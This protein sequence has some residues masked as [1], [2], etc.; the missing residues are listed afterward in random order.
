MQQGTSINPTIVQDLFDSAANAAAKGQAQFLTPIEF[1]QALA[2]GL[3]EHRPVI[4]DLNCGPGQLLQAVRNGSTQHL[5]G[6][7]IE[8]CRNLP[9]VAVERITADLTR[10]YPLLVETDWKA[11]LFALN[12]PWD[13][14]WYRDRLSLLAESEAEAVREAFAQR[15][16]RLGPDTIDSTVATLMIALDRC[17][18]RGEGFLIANESTLQRLI[19]GEGAPYGGLA[20]HIWWHAVYDGNTVTGEERIGFDH[21]QS[22]FK[23]GV[24]YFSRSHQTG[25]GPSDQSISRAWHRGSEVRQGYHCQTDTLEL[26]RGVREEWRRQEGQRVPQPYNIWLQGDVIRTGLSVFQEHSSKV[27]KTEARE[28]YQ[29]NQKRPMDLVLQRHT[30]DL[31]FRLVGETK[32]EGRRQK[33]EDPAPNT[34]PSSFHWRV[35]PALVAEVQRCWLAYQACR[36]PLYPLPKIQRLGYLEE[37]DSIQ[38]IEDFCIDEVP[39]FRRGHSYPLRTKTIAVKRKGTK[40]NLVGEPESLEYTGQELATW[41][42][43]DP[44]EDHCFLDARA[45]ANGVE[46]PPL[47]DYRSGEPRLPSERRVHPLQKLVDHFH[48]PDV[49]DVA[50]AN[51]DGFKLALERLQ[52]LQEYGELKLKPFQLQDLS[53]AALHDGLI[54]G[55]DT[56]L[57]KT[58]AGFL[59]PLL[60]LGW[61][62]EPAP[63]QRD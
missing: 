17:S 54:L 40:L 2:A 42:K 3:P 35:D 4:V 5:L 30:R 29:L 15:D 49:P 62:L 26:W 9:G 21:R 20:Q 41:V 34:T 33:E 14:H 53:R 51:P 25:P 48:I 63:G 1:G 28:L 10:L 24:I 59:W 46:L 13:L 31:L 60:K 27:N 58:L 55:W 52:Q 56:G 50:A 32:A 18:Y 7:D 8:P 11:D 38:A 12:P 22:E 45:L 36:A 39:V 47:F 16:P 44:G 57:G 23:T 43:D 37:E 6:A 19:F 61:T